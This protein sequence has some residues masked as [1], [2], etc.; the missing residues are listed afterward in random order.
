MRSGASTITMQ[1]A[2]LLRAG[3]GGGGGGRTWRGKISQ[4]FWA[5][6]LEAH[7][8][9]QQILEQY[10][11]RVPLGQGTVGVDGAAELYFNASASRVSLGQA[12]LL[13]GLAS[14]P[15]ND[16]PFVAP[17]RSRS[18]R[19]VV[20]GRIARYGYATQDALDRAAREPLIVPRRVPPFLAPHFTSRV[21]QWLDTTAASGTRSRGR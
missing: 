7:L 20:L 4:A 19:A 10:L 16:N 15:S 3:G 18:R 13:A 1:L 9:K 21:L 2:R 11:N 6:R 8:S 17:D 14:S 12:A 5:L